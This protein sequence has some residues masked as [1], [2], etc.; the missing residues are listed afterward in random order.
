MTWNKI[1]TAESTKDTSKKFVAIDELVI[2]H[3]RHAGDLNIRVVEKPGNCFAIRVYQDEWDL[4]REPADNQS[5]TLV[6]A[7]LDALRFALELFES[8]VSEIRSAIRAT[9]TEQESTSKSAV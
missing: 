8:T 7:K 1:E 9:E 6:T 5:I 4:G 3:P 2:K